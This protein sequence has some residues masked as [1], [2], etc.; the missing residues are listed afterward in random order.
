MTF[1]CRYQPKDDFSMSSDFYF[2]PWTHMQPFLMG[3]LLGYVLWR[4]KGHKI[5]IHWVK[6]TD[7]SKFFLSQASKSFKS[8]MRFELVF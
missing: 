6:Q 3:I 5:N 4:T 8:R 2:K 1:F 7:C